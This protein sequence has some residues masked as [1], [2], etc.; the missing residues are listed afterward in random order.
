M[1]SIFRLYAGWE[2]GPH[3]HMHTYTTRQ[4]PDY[5]SQTAPYQDREGMLIAV[6]SRGDGHAKCTCPHNSRAETKKK[7]PKLSRRLERNGKGDGICAAELRAWLRLSR[8]VDDRS[9]QL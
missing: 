9:C 5:A 7:K 8:H 3:V 6:L 2:V 1:G 4:Q